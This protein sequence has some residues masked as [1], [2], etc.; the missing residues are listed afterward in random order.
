MIALIKGAP[1]W[2]GSCLEFGKRLTPYK[3][4][5]I[6]KTK[7]MTMRPGIFSPRHGK[8]VIA[9]IAVCGL[10]GV[11]MM[12]AHAEGN[13]K[14]DEHQDKGSHQDQKHK[15][16]RHGDRDRRGHEEPRFYPQPVYVPPAVYYPPQ[17]S[18]GIT[19]FLPLDIHIR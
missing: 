1:I 4:K 14:R 12:P 17:Q 15:D 5:L 6:M 18:A 2:P 13:D 19:L 9:V 8:A 16:H 3:G 7:P 11:S 10:A